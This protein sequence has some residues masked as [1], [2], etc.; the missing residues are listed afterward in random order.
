M[1]PMGRVARKALYG[2]SDNAHTPGGRL[3]SGQPLLVSTPHM[4][5]IGDGDGLRRPFAGSRSLL[6]LSRQDQGPFVHC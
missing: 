1:P 4:A 5:V 2:V 6:F 3:W